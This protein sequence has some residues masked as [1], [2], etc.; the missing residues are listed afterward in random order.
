MGRSV[1]WG[2]FWLLFLFVERDY[3]ILE[4]LNYDYIMF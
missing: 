2:P 3:S 1:P 4:L